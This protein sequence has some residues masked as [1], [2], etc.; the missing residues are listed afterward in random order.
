MQSEIQREILYMSEI[1]NQKGSEAIK[2][3]SICANFLSND[4]YVKKIKE[5]LDI[6][7]DSPDFDILYDFSHIIMSVVRANKQANYYKDVKPDRM[8][9]VLYST[10]FNYLTKYKNELFNTID[11]GKFRVLFNNSFELLEQSPLIMKIAKEGWFL[12]IG[13]I[14]GINCITD[15]TI[16]I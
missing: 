9:Y 3:L 7:F 14:L 5:D 2:V 8:K 1:D 4:D 15:G 10:I 12:C 16:H 13:R 11:I 6:I